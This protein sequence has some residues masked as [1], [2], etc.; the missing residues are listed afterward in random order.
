MKR[1]LQVLPNPATD[2][3]RINGLAGVIA[4]TIHDAGGRV[5]LQGVLNE[6]APVAVDELPAGLYTVRTTDEHYRAL[7]FVK[8]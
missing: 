8:Q 3:I 6:G 4:Y 1:T 2:H 5:V 7:R